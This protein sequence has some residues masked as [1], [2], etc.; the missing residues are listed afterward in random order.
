MAIRCIVTVQNV[1]D[2]VAP[3]LGASTPR[4]LRCY[5][6]TALLQ[7]MYVLIITNAEDM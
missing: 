1:D 5:F 3:D 6:P 2:A 4:L 7:L